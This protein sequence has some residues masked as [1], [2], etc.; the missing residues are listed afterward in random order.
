MGFF[1]RKIKEMLLKKYFYLLLL[2]ALAAGVSCSTFIPDEQADMLRA[3]ETG[4]GSASEYRM[5]QEVTVN[6]IT[7]EKGKR[8]KIII[9]A[10]DDWVKVYAY[11]A[12]ED[13]LKS[14]RVLI[15]HMFDTD[16]P[17]KKF[18]R[19]LFE[20]ALFKV[21]VKAGADD[22]EKDKKKPVRKKR[23]K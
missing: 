13:L 23:K 8:V 10:G 19:V 21:I 20:E 4:N 12:E 2:F 14:I 11:R 17:D 3:Y 6:D 16:F 18:D 22:E 9:V 5:L 15:L 7:L 1:R